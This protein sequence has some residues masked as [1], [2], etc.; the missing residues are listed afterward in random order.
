MVLDDDDDDGSSLPSFLPLL[1]SLFLPQSYLLSSPLFPPLFF[2]TSHPA[3]SNTLCPTIQTPAP[4]LQDILATAGLDNGKWA[5]CAQ[6]LRTYVASSVTGG[7]Y[8]DGS[9][10]M[11]KVTDSDDYCNH[12]HWHHP[13]AAT[14]YVTHLV[15]NVCQHSIRYRLPNNASPALVDSTLPPLPCPPHPATPP[16]RSFHQQ[17]SSSQPGLPRPVSVG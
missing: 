17:C 9:D 11:T 4:L 3:F 8:I 14:V 1:I 16:T 10:A 5:D 15:N 7:E 2:P 13:M 6:S 12:V